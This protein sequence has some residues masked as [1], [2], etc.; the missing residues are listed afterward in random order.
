MLEPCVSF[1]PIMSL[2]CH[3]SYDI[4]ELIY[5]KEAEFR[6]RRRE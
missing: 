4:T 6:P 2:I 3:N 1:L 5:I